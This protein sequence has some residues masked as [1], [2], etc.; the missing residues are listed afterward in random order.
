MKQLTSQSGVATLIAL[1]LIGMLTLIGIAAIST[2]EDEVTIAGNE[3]QEMRAFY[4]AEGGLEMAAAA[5]NREYDSTG[6]P[7]TIMPSGEANYNFCKVTYQ[8]TDDGAATQKQLSA[9]TLAGLHALVKSFTISSTG[10]NS[11][12]N[13]RVQLSQT[14]ETALVPIFQFAVFY[15]NDLEIAPGPDMTL[16]G[17]VHSNGNMW[18]QANSSL[19]MDSYVTASGDILHGRKGAGGVSTGDVRIKNTDGDHVSMKMGS[20]FLDASYSDWYDSSVA[21]WGGRVQDQSHGQGE[22]NLPLTNSDDPHKLIERAGGNPDSYENLATL[23]IIDGVA[24]RLMPDGTWQDVT[25]AMV[26]DGVLTY[27]SN[28]FYD[29]RESEWVDATEIDVKAL[30]DHGYGPRNGVVYFADDISSSSEWPAVRLVN[31]SEIGDVQGLSF[32][33]ENPMYTVGDFNSVDK[34]PVSLMGDAITFL[35]NNWDA[36]NYDAK[37]TASKYDR[38]ADHTT[39]NASYLTGNTETTSTNYNGGFENLPRFLEVWSNK[40]FKWTGSAVNL[41]YSQQANSLWSGS[42]YSPPIRTWAYDTDLDDPNNL[43]PE[44]PVVRVFQRTGWRQEHVALGTLAAA[45]ADDN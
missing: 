41:W 19:D 37:S 6:S 17:R 38:T 5:L 31:G 18:L 14:F 28:Q 9:G 30:Y 24:T 12:E 7:P 8:V 3:L 23:K 42:Y 11:Q 20:D 45:H 39:V 21:R 10:E 22:L 35:S 1:I 40:E 15:G 29:Q 13:S 4:A 34:K 33:S 43:P 44:S 2:S 36:N 16:L 25:A 32:V 27:T 26:S